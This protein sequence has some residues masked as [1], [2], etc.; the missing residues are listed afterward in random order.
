VYGIGIHLHSKPMALTFGSNLSD[1]EKDW[2]LGE[3]HGFW[4]NKE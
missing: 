2:L 3:L 1:E 4:Q